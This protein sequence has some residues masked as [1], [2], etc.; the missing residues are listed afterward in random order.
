MK[1]IYLTCKLWDKRICNQPEL[2]EL[3]QP[4]EGSLSPRSTGLSEIRQLNEI[5]CLCKFPLMIDIR[6]CPSC[7]NAELQQEITRGQLGINLIY[8]YNCEE[9]GRILYSH[10]NLG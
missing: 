2:R 1:A 8:N 7:G 6:Q 4:E 9:C 5:C 10:Q 3:Y